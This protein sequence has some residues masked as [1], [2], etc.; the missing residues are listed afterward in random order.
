MLLDMKAAIRGRGIYRVSDHNGIY[1]D[2]LSADTLQNAANYFY[3]VAH[4]SK[5]SLGQSLKLANAGVRGPDSY[6]QPGLWGLE[7]R[8]IASSDLPSEVGGM[9]NQAQW[10][11]THRSYGVS[12]ERI[13]TWL[14]AVLP[15]GGNPNQAIRNAWYGA[16]PVESAIARP[17]CARLSKRLASWIYLNRPMR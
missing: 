3:Q 16:R 6:D 9:L 2:N 17:T 1:S 13:K 8:A 4:G 15:S 11:L 14:E 5:P 7:V 12:R 10:N